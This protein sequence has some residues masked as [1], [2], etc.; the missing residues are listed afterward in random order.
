MSLAVVGLL[1]GDTVFPI[2]VSWP[3]KHLH[4][5]VKEEIL[6]LFYYPGGELH[7]LPG[8]ATYSLLSQPPTL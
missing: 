2:V 3:V 1:M 6:P 7:C 5:T 4:L 8:L